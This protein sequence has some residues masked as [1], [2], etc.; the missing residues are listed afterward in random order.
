MVVFLSPTIS[1]NTWQSRTSPS[2]PLRLCRALHNRKWLDRL[3]AGL[4]GRNRWRLSLVII[5]I[6]FASGRRTL[7]T[8][9][10]AVGIHSDSADYY[11]FLQPV[12]RKG[13]D[14]AERLFVVLLVRLNVGSR[15]LL[16]VDD[17][18]TKRYGPKVQGAGIHH[19]P[20]PG[21]VDQKIL[22]GHHIWVTISLM[23]RH[24][25]WHTISLP[26]VGLLYV[27]S[28]ATTTGRLGRA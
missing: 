2:I 11:D 9:L 28:T 26:L 19:N 27:R 24:P 1:K 12:G 15:L 7:T 21:P 4:H 8:W 18:P 6:L 5:G 20:T 23:L 22:Y 13:K 10:R 14:L 25:L 17:S 3:A 16:A